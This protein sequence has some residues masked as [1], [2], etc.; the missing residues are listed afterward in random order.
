MFVRA[1]PA[2]L[3]QIICKMILNFQAI[4]KSILD[5]DNNYQRN[6]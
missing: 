1:P 2:I 5:P 3:L 6:Y 4:V